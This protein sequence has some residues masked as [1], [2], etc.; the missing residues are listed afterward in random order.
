MPPIKRP[1]RLR[2]KHFI[3]EWREYRGLTQE[4]AAERIGMSYTSVGRI[5]NS[6]VPY[7][8]DF[9]EAAA[10]AYNCEPWDLLNRDPNKEGEVIDLMRH[11]DDAR[12]AEAENFLRYLSEKKSS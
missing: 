12:R 5:E 11:L 4:Q 10:F 8:Q 1:P 9:L 3:R 6:Q 2:R 7:S